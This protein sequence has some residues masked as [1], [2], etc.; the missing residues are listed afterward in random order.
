VFGYVVS[1]F[2]D[3]VKYLVEVVVVDLVEVLNLVELL[4][5]E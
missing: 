4:F 1:L 5:V 2:F 3:L